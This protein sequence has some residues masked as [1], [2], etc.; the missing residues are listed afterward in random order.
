MRIAV[1]FGV[2]GMMVC[3]MLMLR[4]GKSASSSIKADSDIRQNDGFF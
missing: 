3:V 2:N 1:L 4:R